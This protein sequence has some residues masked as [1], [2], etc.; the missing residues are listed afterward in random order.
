MASAARVHTSYMGKSD[1]EAPPDNAGRLL[2]QNRA[3]WKKERQVKDKE[4]KERGEAKA[5]REREQEQR[6]NHRLN[7][8]AQAERE[9]VQRRGRAERNQACRDAAYRR[10]L[11]AQ[12]ER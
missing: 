5:E 6:K 11:K 7:R 2:A 12:Q 1:L 8:E 3:Q 4:R 10:R 9:E